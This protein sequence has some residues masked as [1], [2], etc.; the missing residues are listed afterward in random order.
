MKKLRLMVTSLVFTT[1]L[2]AAAAPKIE[3]GMKEAKLLKLMGPPDKKVVFPSKGDSDRARIIYTWADLRV[4][5][6]DGEVDSTK[7]VDPKTKEEEKRREEEKRVAADI[8]K[9][10]RIAALENDVRRMEALLMPA[11][12]RGTVS[13]EE[14]ASLRLSI[15]RARGEIE[16]LLKS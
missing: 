1:A 15:E 4:M 13:E 12:D 10:R 14:K 3:P 7:P 9:K 2:L 5:V 6:V 11:A 8:V 16:V